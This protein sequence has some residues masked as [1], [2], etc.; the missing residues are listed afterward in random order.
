M[1]ATS[2]TTAAG[3]PAARATATPPTSATCWC[4]R[5]SPQAAST[6]RALCNPV[7]PSHALPM[8]SSAV[9]SGY[10]FLGPGPAEKTWLSAT[11]ML[12]TCLN[13]TCAQVP[14]WLM[15]VH[16]TGSRHSS[17]RSVRG[18]Q[19]PA[20]PEAGAHGGAGDD[21]FRDWAVMAPHLALPG[22]WRSRHQV[23]QQ[24]NP[25]AIPDRSPSPAHGSDTLP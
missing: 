14:C 8:V 12:C 20:Q 10:L 16:A 15:G 24:L 23:L 2:C 13:D 22:Q 4:S 1:W 3:T 17:L 25:N 19:G 5:A 9:R 21:Y 11:R 6:V 18:V 7:V